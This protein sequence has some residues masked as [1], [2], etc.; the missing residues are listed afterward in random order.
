MPKPEPSPNLG[1]PPALVSPWSW[2][3]QDWRGWTLSFSVTFG[4]LTHLILGISTFKDP[5]CEFT[6][7]IIGVGPD[8]TPDTSTKVIPVP[9]GSN[10]VLA[11]L[12]TTLATVGLTTIDNLL[13]EQITAAV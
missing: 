12:L 3:T 1:N 5:D 6:K 2:Q 13:A 8:G 10:N 9:A 7:I 11:A 4:P